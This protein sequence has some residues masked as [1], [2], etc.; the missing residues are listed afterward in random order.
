MMASAYLD[1]LRGRL[2]AVRNKLDDE[3]EKVPVDYTKIAEFKWQIENLTDEL[4]LYNPTTGELS[5]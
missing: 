4:K 2:T 5:K 3:L 1:D